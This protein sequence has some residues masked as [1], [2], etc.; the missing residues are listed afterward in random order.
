MM[1]ILK[2]LPAYSFGK[3]KLRDL[4]TSLPNTVTQCILAPILFRNIFWREEGVGLWRHSQLSFLSDMK[5]QSLWR[6]RKMRN[7]KQGKP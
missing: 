1:T 7:V 3:L 2:I 5:C 6:K 4:L